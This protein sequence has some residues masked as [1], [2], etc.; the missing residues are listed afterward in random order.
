M[1]RQTAVL[2]VLLAAAP[3]AA[4]DLRQRVESQDGTVRLSFAAKEGVCGNGRNITTH[5]GDSKY[6]WESDCEPGPVRVALEV[7]GGRVTAARAYVGGRWRPLAGA[8]DLG[9]VGAREAAGFFLSLAERSDRIRG[10]VVLPA[11][12]ADSA[13]VWRDLLRIAK[14]QQ[15][16]REVRKNAVFWLSQEAGDAATEGLTEL[17]G[18]DTDDREVRKQ[19]VFALSQ[20]PHDRGVPALLQVARTNKDPQIRKTAIFWLGQSDDPRAIAL[21]EE[22]LTRR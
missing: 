17:V 20:L 2:V 14:N 11:I 1:I 9:T 12:L 19:A 5:R 8:R 3:A 16:N 7:S 6:G 10:D 18:R 21:F 4:Q 13:E 15:A 22:L